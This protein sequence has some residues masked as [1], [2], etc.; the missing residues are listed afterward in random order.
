MAIIFFNAIGIF[1]LLAGSIVFSALSFTSIKGLPLV[2]LPLV[3]LV[4][5]DSMYRSIVV[6]SQLIEKA[7]DPSDGFNF[8][9]QGFWMDVAFSRYG[10]SLMLLPAWLFSVLLIMLAV[11]SYYLG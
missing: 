11:G 10:G 3:V 9:K 7:N 1:M 6:K 8:P 2:V 4:A 5:I